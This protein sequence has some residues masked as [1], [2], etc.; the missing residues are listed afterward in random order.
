MPFE[1]DSETGYVS[2]TE[3]AKHEGIMG[4][5]VEPKN[6]KFIAKRGTLLDYNVRYP[7]EMNTHAK[8][9]HKLT[10][11]LNFIYLSSNTPIINDPA[12]PKKINKAPKIEL[13]VE[14]KP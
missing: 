2:S 10:V 6:I 3:N 4:I 5:I 8:H 11:S 13:S 12:T 7:H 9:A 14:V 1:I